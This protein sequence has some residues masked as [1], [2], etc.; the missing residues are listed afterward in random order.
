MILFKDLEQ[1]SIEWLNLRL[2]KFTA[3]NA[4]KIMNNLKGGSWASDK[5]TYFWQLLEESLTGL[6]KPQ[7]VSDAMI[8]GKEQENSAREF[9]MGFNGVQVEEIAFGVHDKYP[10][11]G[12]SPDGLIGSDGLCEFKCPSTRVMLEILDTNEPNPD[13]I[14]QVQFQMWVSERD[15]CD[16]CYYDPRLP[17]DLQFKQFRVSQDPEYI[18]LLEASILEMQEKLQETRANIYK[19]KG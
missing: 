17:L 18:K 8:W 7:F 15:W 1:G 12:M 4:S 9:Y 19:N 2:G 14:A 13:Y 6:P 11:V 5:K 10:F 16:L 3:S